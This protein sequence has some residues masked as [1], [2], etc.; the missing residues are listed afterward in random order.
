VQGLGRRLG[1]SETWLRAKIAEGAIPARRH[2]T[3]KWWLIE[4]DPALLGRLEKLA[5]IRRR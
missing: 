4:D 2:P 3:T 5:A 1:T